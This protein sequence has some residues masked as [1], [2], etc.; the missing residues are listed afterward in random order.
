MNDTKQQVFMLNEFFHYVFSP[1]TNFSLKDF[2]VQKPSL[3]NLTS[4]KI[5]PEI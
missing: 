2:K 4:R 5:Q 1:K 3:T